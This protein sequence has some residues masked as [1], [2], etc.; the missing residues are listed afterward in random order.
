MAIID[1]SS[2]EM[3]RINNGSAYTCL[4]RRHVTSDVTRA[5]VYR[6]NTVT[7]QHAE[8]QQRY[9]TTTTATTTTTTTTAN[10]VLHDVMQALAITF[11]INKDS[12]YFAELF[13]ELKSHAAVAT[14]AAAAAV[15]SQQ[16]HSSAHAQQVVAA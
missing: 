4:L 14:A 3:L 11:R 12:A 8:Q 7:R 2:A 13:R 1:R 15:T 6:I 10:T 9:A 5:S 16:Q